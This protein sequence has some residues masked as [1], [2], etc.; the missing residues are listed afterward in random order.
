MQ[1]KDTTKNAR[2]KSAVRKASA[3][4]CKSRSTDAFTQTRTILMSP[5]FRCFYVFL[6][7]FSFSFF[8]FFYAHSRLKIQHPQ[9]GLSRKN[10]P[11]AS[12]AEVDLCRSGRCGSQGTAQPHSEDVDCVSTN[13]FVNILQT[14]VA[15]LATDCSC[16]FCFVNT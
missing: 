1:F 3:V 8:V 6:V 16:A 5:P 4:P 12:L 15:S 11:E 13:F 9:I 10:W 2:K 7:I 14:I